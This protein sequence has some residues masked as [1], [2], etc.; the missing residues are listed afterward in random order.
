MSIFNW[1]IYGGYGIAFPVGRYIPPLNAWGLVS[2][3]RRRPF[4]AT[5]DIMKLCFQGWRVTYYGAGIIALIIGVLTWFT[6]KEPA[7]MSIGEEESKENE[8]AKKVTIWNVICDP[9]VIMLVLAASVRHC[10]EFLAANLKFRLEKEVEK[11]EIQGVHYSIGSILGSWTT[12]G[13]TRSR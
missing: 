9:R 10:G 13:Y 4:F 12:T 7:R 3:T 2:G 8:N 11:L 1:G 5:G 6:L